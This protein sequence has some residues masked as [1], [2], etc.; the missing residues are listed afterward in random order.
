MQLTV[1]QFNGSNY[2]GWNKS[3]R[4]ALGT[5]SKLGFVDGS[6]NRPIEGSP[7]LQK[8][9]RCDYMVRC[10]ILNSLTSEI[11]ESFM[12]VQS[13]KELWEEL[14]KRFSEANGPLIYQLHRDLCLLSQENEP[15]S[16]Y[17]SK[18]KKIWDELQDIDAFPICSCGV[19]ANCKCNLMKGLHEKESRSRLIQFLMGLNSGYDTIRGQI[20]S[21][22]PLPTVNRAYY[23]IQ[24]IEK[25]RQVTG[26]MQEKQEVEACNTYKQTTKGSGKRD[27]KKGKLDRFYDHC[28]VKG[29]LI[30]QC[31]K[32][33]G[34][35]EWYKEKFG[36]KVR[37]AAHV[38]ILENN[39]AQPTP[40]DHHYGPSAEVSVTPALVNAVCQE[41]LKT[42]NGRNSSKD[43]VHVSSNAVSDMDSGPYF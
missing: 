33:H 8:W 42:F 16:L 25:Q 32:I 29:H 22:D 19:I 18:M 38:S 39:H 6:M 1:K 14:A 15:L 23:M 28:K 11:S 43:Q 26:A 10:W 9:L 20:L 34:Y 4:M 13:A 12:Y 27:F 31:F 24:Q 17:F 35:P 30:D 41:L 36:A 2:T 5:K 3:A 40:L 37:N 7:N 21:M